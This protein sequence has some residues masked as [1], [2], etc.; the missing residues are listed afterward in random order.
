MIHGFCRKWSTCIL[1][2]KSYI[3]TLS[4]G[5]N[6]HNPGDSWCLPFQFIFLSNSSISQWP[7]HH[8]WKVIDRKWQEWRQY[9][10]GLQRLCPQ[11]LQTLLSAGARELCRTSRSGWVA[12]RREQRSLWNL[13]NPC[14]SDTK[15][16]KPSMVPA[17][18]PGVPGCRCLALLVPLVHPHLPAATWGPGCRGGWGAACVCLRTCP[19]PGACWR[20]VQSS[21]VFSLYPSHPLKTG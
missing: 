5:C 20:W 9:R 11:V 10:M 21:A 14:P 12:G 17:K 16:V 13:E 19:R 18:S 1:T 3:L 4:T 8:F 2:R 6:V 15:R 7:K